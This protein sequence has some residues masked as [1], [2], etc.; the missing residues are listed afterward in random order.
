MAGGMT[1]GGSSTTQ[2]RQRLKVPSTREAR[3]FSQGPVG[4]SPYFREWIGDPK[5]GTPRI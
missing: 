2:L 3:A 4:L 1:I 5:W